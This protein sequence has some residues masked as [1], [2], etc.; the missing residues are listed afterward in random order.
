[1]EVHEPK[2][3]GRCRMQVLSDASAVSLHPFVI[4]SVEPGS[5]VVTDAW[6]GYSGIEAHGYRR[7][8]HSQRAA[9]LRGDDPYG[10][11]PGVHRVSALAKRW[12]LGT[13][14]GSVDAAHLQVYLDEI[15]FRFNRRRSYSRGLV[16]YRVMQLAVDHDLILDPEPKRNPP[17]GRAGWRHPPSL[18]R[19]RAEH[20]W[21]AA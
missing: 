18:E 12:L 4:A 7:E 11:L 1:V 5:S 2:G 13:H 15:V 14:Q 19:P 16:F 20:P 8:R 6:Q 10:L 17:P 21:R 9:R 3:Y